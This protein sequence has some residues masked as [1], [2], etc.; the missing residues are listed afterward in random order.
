MNVNKNGNENVVK[1]LDEII[2][3]QEAGD[4]A[5]LAAV[6]ALPN[7][8]SINDQLKSIVLKEANPNEV[9]IAAFQKLAKNNGLKDA[10]QLVGVQEHC[11]K[12]Y[13]LT[14]LKNLK[15]SKNPVRRALAPDSV[16][17]KEEPSTKFG[18]SKN[19]VYEYGPLF[20][21]VDVVYPKDS[22]ITQSITARISRVANGMF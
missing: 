1:L 12:N 22:N 10:N 11:V 14:Y 5:R 3:S 4:A 8:A 7:E 9:R 17:I 19:L 20:I 16:E 2:N 6:K 13:I 15:N 18:V 21:D